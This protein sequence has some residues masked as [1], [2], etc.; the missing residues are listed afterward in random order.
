MPT[1][2]WVLE[3]QL[4]GPTY[5]VTTFPPRRA[6]LLAIVPAMALA[7]VAGFSDRPDMAVG[8]LVIGALV[9]AF[10][11][12]CA[13][14]FRFLAAETWL[15]AEYAIGKNLVRLDDVVKATVT[16]GSYTYLTLRDSTGG[17]V[18]IQVGSTLP[19]IRSQVIRGVLQSQQRGM[20]L[21]A[22]VARALGIPS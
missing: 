16:S 7:G 3:R 12:Y 20:R 10:V 21:D 5:L 9:A 2:A 8:I 4:I 22:R 17:H 15:A 1:P 11:A 6:A 13:A 18:A 19:R 14:R